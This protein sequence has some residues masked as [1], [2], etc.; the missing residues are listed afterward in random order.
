VKKLYDLVGRVGQ[1]TAFLKSQLIVATRLSFSDS[2]FAARRPGVRIPSRPPKT[3]I[4]TGDFES[5]ENPCFYFLLW[6]TPGAR[7]A[8]PKVNAGPLDLQPRWLLTPRR[9][10]QKGRMGL[11]ALIRRRRGRIGCSV[12]AGTQD[13]LPP[14]LQPR[15]FKEA[16]PPGAG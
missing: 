5:R 13:E 9:R 3:R 6:W 12:S 7:S 15:I 2:P 8:S 4:N 11:S 10:T 14:P 16:T 1:F